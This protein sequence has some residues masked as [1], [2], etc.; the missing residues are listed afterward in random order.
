MQSLIDC[1]NSTLSQIK[2]INS[3]QSYSILHTHNSM[4]SLIERNNST[5][6]LNEL[7]NLRTESDEPQQRSLGFNQSLP[8][9]AK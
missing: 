9:L 3:M 4:Q 1:N 7:H 5:Q 8:Y 6:A 2:Y